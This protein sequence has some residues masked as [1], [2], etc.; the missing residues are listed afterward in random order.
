MRWIA[1]LLPLFAVAQL[2]ELSVQNF[3]IDYLF[4]TGRAYVE[5]LI[6]FGRDFTPADGEEVTMSREADYFIIEV[7]SRQRIEVKDVPPA[8]LD[9]RKLDLT[10]LNLGTL[11]KDIN[12]NLNRFSYD[13]PNS[14]T[15]VSRICPIIRNR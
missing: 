9:T 14:S 4:P 5:K 3:S 13:H 12:L 10:Q 15:E 6:L 7:G 1:L 11:S 8:I 2:P